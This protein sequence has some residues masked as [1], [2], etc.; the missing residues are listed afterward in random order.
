MTSINST[1]QSLIQSQ[2]ANVQLREDISYR[3]AAKTLA[4]ARQ[5][6]D[7]ALNLLEAAAEIPQQS[8]NNP[9][10]MGAVVSGLGQNLDISG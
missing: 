9:P 1:T 3:I 8:A 7:M 2:L 10:T 6:G 5:Q 4:A